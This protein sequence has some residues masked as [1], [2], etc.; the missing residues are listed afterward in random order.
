MIQIDADF[1]IPIPDKDTEGLTNFRDRVKSWY[2]TINA[3][4]ERGAVFKSPSLHEKALSHKLF[5][6][7]LSNSGKVMIKDNEIT[8][9]AAVHLEAILSEWDKEII[10]IHARLKN[11]VINKL[12]IESTDDD[13]KIRVRSLELLGKTISLFSERMEVNV[14][15][16]TVSEIEDEITRTLTTYLDSIKPS[17][18]GIDL[19]TINVGNIAA[20]IDAEYREI[21]GEP[22]ELENLF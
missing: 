12:I 14:N 5:K 21:E 11:Y 3:L 6:E 17:T 15:H 4:T 9:G 2:L 13:P 22:N 1:D 18:V 7:Y 10:N 20:A 16:K 19:S 8:T